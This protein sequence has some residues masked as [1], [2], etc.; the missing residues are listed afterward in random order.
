MTDTRDAGNDPSGIYIARDLSL[1]EV[2]NKIGWSRKRLREVWFE[3]PTS[4][5]SGSGRYKVQP[6]GLDRWLENRGKAA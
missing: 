2:A 5:R 3:I 1:A 6:S 4:Y